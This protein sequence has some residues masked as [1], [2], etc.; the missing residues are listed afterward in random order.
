M[1]RRILFFF[2]L[3]RKIIIHRSIV[4]IKFINRAIKFI[5]N[6][7][8]V[9]VQGRDFSLDYT[10]L[11]SLNEYPDARRQDLKFISLR[12][13]L[14]PDVLGNSDKL[15]PAETVGAGYVSDSQCVIWAPNGNEGDWF[16]RLYDEG[17]RG[18]KILLANGHHDH[19][20]PSADA[21]LTIPTFGF[22]RQIY[23]MLDK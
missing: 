21:Y 15:I 19:L 4:L 9:I 11:S 13:I 6:M 3:F 7:E 23:E 18:K 20:K 2:T 10:I 14:P 16:K 8:K 1:R 5:E 12:S 22:A 17:Y